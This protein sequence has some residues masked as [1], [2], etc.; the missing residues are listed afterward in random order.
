MSLKVLSVRIP[1]VMH[2]Y[3]KH[4]AAL[5]NKSVQETLAEMIY[6]YQIN[7]KNYLDALHESVDT[8]Y[9]YVEQNAQ[10]PYTAHKGGR[11]DA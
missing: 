10:N 3:I 11:N 1:N 8:A 6:F 9:Y 2:T 7:D 5:T 4:R